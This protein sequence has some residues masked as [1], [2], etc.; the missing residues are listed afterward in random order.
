MLD[1]R[2][3]ALPF[4]SV[5]P[6]IELGLLVREPD[7]GWSSC[8]GLHLEDMET[9]KILRINNWDWSASIVIAPVVSICYLGVKMRKGWEGGRKRK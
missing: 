2:I 8:R 9:D 4:P 6:E 3:E 5:C 7:R 1:E